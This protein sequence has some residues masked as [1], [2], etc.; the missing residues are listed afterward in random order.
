MQ[1]RSTYVLTHLHVGSRHFL[2]TLL[3]NTHTRSPSGLSRSSLCLPVALSPYISLSHVC[4]ALKQGKLLGLDPH[5]TSSAVSINSAATPHPPSFSSTMVRL[6][7]QRFS[8]RSNTRS[9]TP[10]QQSRS[11]SPMRSPTESSLALRVNVVKVR[12]APPHPLP[13]ALLA[14]R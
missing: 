9:N 12:K 5:A 13:T 14:R 8:S 11:T 1:Q 4:R 10:L 6:F 2:E 7:P 3:C